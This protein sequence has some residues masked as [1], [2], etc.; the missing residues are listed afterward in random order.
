MEEK[1]KSDIAI[2]LG[3]AGKYKILTFIGLALS[4]IAMFLGMLP[5]ICIWLVARDLIAVAPNWTLATGVQKYGWMAF[6]F[7]VVG[8]LVYF[9]ALMCTHLAAFRTASNIR[10]QGMAHLMEAP[11]G[12]FDSNASGLLRNRL[13][14]AAS[15]TETLLA[16][17]LADIVGSIVMFV[18]M[19]VL[20]FVF[21]WRMGA[22]CLLAAVVSVAAMFT[23]MGGKNAQLM[24]EYQAAQDYMSKA[25]T[26][27]V[28]GIP[29]VKVFQQ[30]VY[31]FKAF[32]DAIEDYSQKAEHYAIKVCRVP[33][34][35]N[36]TATE[37]AFIFLVPAAVLIAP[38]AL[39]DG[40]FA[41]FVTN[42]AFYAVFSAIVSTALARIMFATNGIMLASSAIKRIDQV[43]GAPTLKVTDNPKEPKDNSIEFKD[44]SFTYEGADIPAIDHVSFKVE[45]GQTVALVGPS[46]GGKTTAASLIPR[47]WDV[48]SGAVYVGGVDVRDMDPHVLMDRIAFV[49]QNNRLFKA[50]IFE[51]VR[52]AKPGATREEVQRALDAAQCG[53]IL[54]K[55]PNGMDTVIGTA[56]VY[57]SGGEQQRVALARAILKDAPIVI[58]DEATA[59][60]DPENEVLIQKA[61]ATLTKG[62]TVIMIAHRLSTVVSA[63]KIIVLD[64][65]KTVEEGS[66]ETLKQK[67]GMYSHMWAD[68]NQA[69]NWRISAGE[70]M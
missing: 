54:A 25:G 61:F 60:A 65:G 28:R 46:G 5:Y 11:L 22:S 34:S 16:H 63:D 33:Q 30:T 39:K 55:L 44:V 9:A 7:A 10:K 62:K 52:A 45:P 66:H 57:L 35:V 3:Y 69:V 47:F 70:A 51:N 67:N 36:L 21:D 68:Y 23:M 14:G 13:D 59:F 41:G 58:L 64:G 26:E 56:G 27:Y 18:G 37:G 40:N 12:F 53:D 29:V 1:K 32:K 20:M 19:I 17:N 8:I 6:V 2:L 4:G 24:H 15:E 48:T 38:G 42:F 50:S 49:F 31:S 43:M